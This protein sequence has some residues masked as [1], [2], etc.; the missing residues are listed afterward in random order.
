V[1]AFPTHAGFVPPLPYGTDTDWCRNWV[2][3]GEGLVET[4]G[5]KNAVANPRIVSTDELVLTRTRAVAV[6]WLSNAPSP[7]M[8]AAAR[9]QDVSNEAEVRW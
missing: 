1:L 8:P 5:H 2:E 4:R 9:R 3:A 6:N 7:G